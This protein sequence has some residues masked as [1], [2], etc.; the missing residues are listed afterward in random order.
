MGRGVGGVMIIFCQERWCHD[1]A[2]VLLYRLFAMIRFIFYL[3]LALYSLPLLAQRKSKDAVRQQAFTEQVR[4][5]FGGFPIDS[6]DV[7]LSRYV[8]QDAAFTPTGESDG[9]LKKLFP[10]PLIFDYPPASTKIVYRFPKQNADGFAYSGCCEVVLDYITDGTSDRKAAHLSCLS[11]YVKLVQLLLP[12]SAKHR[13]N[14]MRETNSQWIAA[15]TNLLAPTKTR[16]PTLEMIL[17]ND[18]QTSPVARIYLRYWMQ[19]TN[20]WNSRFL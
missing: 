19:G 9:T 1:F 10:V 3:L 15:A 2:L 5:L 8:R 20:I 18:S 6:S 4:P 14:T 12:L 13:G 11:E 17:D 7:F 16:K